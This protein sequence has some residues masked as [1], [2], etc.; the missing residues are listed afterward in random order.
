MGTGL[1]SKICTGA[2][3]EPQF[4]AGMLCSMSLL[5]VTLKRRPCAGRNEGKDY[6]GRLRDKDKRSNSDVMINTQFF[7][8]SVPHSYE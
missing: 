5:T 3:C 8:K 1:L 6:Q 4:V 2:S 7:N